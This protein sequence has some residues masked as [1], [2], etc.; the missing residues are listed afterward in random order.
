MPAKK[1]EL[2]VCSPRSLPYNK[3]IEAA[4]N[5]VH[6]NPA[7]HPPGHIVALALRGAPP[8]PMR[9]AVL[10]AN[11]WPSTG[12]QLTVGFLDNPEAALRKRI[13]QHMNAWALSA[14]VKFIETKT[15]PQVRIARL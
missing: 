3:R 5:A 14:N 11:R 7:N 13:L 10:I 9:I 1:N 2:I 15:D 4:A 12:V 8:T 6:I